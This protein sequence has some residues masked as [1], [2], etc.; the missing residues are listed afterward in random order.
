MILQRFERE[1]L[2]RQKTV[3]GRRMRPASVM[4]LKVAMDL[5]RA[6]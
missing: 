6:F 5:K 3:Q 4:M 2:T 1:T